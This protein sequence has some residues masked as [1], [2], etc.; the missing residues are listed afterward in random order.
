MARSYCGN[1]RPDNGEVDRRGVAVTDASLAGA[2]VRE[3]AA[4][5]IEDVAAH[6]LAG[7]GDLGDA[8]TTVGRH[9]VTHGPR[10]AILLS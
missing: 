1:Y 4:L 7:P 3:L 2:E 6:L 8:A 10:K 9:P 5:S